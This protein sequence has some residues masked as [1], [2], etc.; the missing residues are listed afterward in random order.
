MKVSFH[1]QA[2]IFYFASK[3]LRIR[4]HLATILGIAVMSDVTIERFVIHFIQCLL[5]IVRS[6]R[7]NLM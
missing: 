6:L 5:L 4:R 1:F 3:G 2:S 7:M